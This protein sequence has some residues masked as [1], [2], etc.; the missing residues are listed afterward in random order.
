MT[1]VGVVVMAYGTPASPDEIEEYYTH[2]RRGRPPS[3][4]QLEELRGRYE[5][6]GGTSPLVEC[7]L[8]QVAAIRRALGD[9]FV[10]Q[11]GTK[12]GRPRI[13]DAVDSLA[14]AG[15]EALI[16]LVLAPHYSELSVG[17]YTARLLS[18]AAAHGLP[19]RTIPSW[20]TL[21]ALIEALAS[22]VL[23][24]IATDDVEVLFT[25]H[26]LPARILDTSDPYRGQL[27]ETAALVAEACG[28]TRWRIAWQSAGR[29]PE[30]WLGPDLCDVLRALPDEGTKHVVVC[31]A[32][33]TSDH[34]E[35][36]YDIDIEARRVAADCGLELV[37]TSSLNDDPAVCS[38][39]ASLI[40]AEAKKL[41]PVSG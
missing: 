31:P 38:S 3:P 39:L 13:E 19:A 23:T 15:V 40:A 16:G 9:G 17:E 1:D 2:I 34:L 37:R 21:P 29:T 25:A 8:A 11:P 14:A 33:F 4:E 26:S 24:A 36:L 32:G 12:H 7:T 20:H 5:A 28:L 10:V 6:I 22:R 35:V 30:P 18:A 27:E 41:A